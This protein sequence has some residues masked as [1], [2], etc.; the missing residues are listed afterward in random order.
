[1]MFDALPYYSL[2]VSFS[3]SV[4]YVVWLIAGMKRLTHWKLNRFI[5]LMIPVVSLIIGLLPFLLPAATVYDIQPVTL[6]LLPLEELPVT[7]ME[8]PVMSMSF[9]DWLQ[10][11]Y[12]VYWVGF[13][14]SILITLLGII[15]V[16]LI[17]SRCK[18]L[19][20]D[21][22]VM[23]YAGKEVV[24]FSWWRW[25]VMS[26]QDFNG[27]GEIILEHEL[28]HLRCG[29]WLD[30][31]LI[32]LVKAL[33]W[34]C[35]ATYLLARDMTVNHEFEADR[36]VIASGYNAA[37]YQTYLIEKATNRRF[38][39]SVVCGINNPYSLIKTRIIMMKKQKSR[40]GSRFRALVLLPAA[41]LIAVIAGSLH[42]AADAQSTNSKTVTVTNKKTVTEC[43]ISLTDE[44]LMQPRE[45]DLVL[46]EI[47]SDIWV[48]WMKNLKYPKEL[49][50]S[51]AQGRVMLKVRVSSSGKITSASVFESSGHKSLDEE[52]IRVVTG[53]EGLTPATYKGNKADIDCLL[54]IVFQQNGTKVP[55]M[56]DSDSGYI[57]GRKGKVK[58]A[59][60]K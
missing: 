15:S 30:L 27:N 21:R 2:I 25:I 36:S 40:S 4:L 57:L 42:F 49:V 48:M 11:L 18:P 55:P 31:L 28:S 16:L 26:E 46:P 5:L 29:H 38:A 32:N 54:P 35:P 7:R 24:P 45:A 8:Q 51:G 23:L 19:P 52:A 34:Y 50:G 33:T 39:N 12:I 56:K 37:E 47:G 22:R 60:N 53:T 41:L 58:P 44:E 17:L 59:A 1:M 20:A 14:V 6:E 3:I 43:A 10:V 13:V 9:S